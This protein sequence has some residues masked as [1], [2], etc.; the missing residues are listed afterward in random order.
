MVKT[1]RVATEHVAPPVGQAAGLDL[2]MSTQDRNALLVRL[3]LAIRGAEDLADA[4]CHL[5]GTNEEELHRLYQ[6]DQIQRAWFLEELGPEAVQLID[7]A[8]EA[9]WHVP[10][11]GI[12]LARACRRCRRLRLGLEPEVPLP[13]GLPFSLVVAGWFS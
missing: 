12:R 5:P 1:P 11:E 9:R 3:R 6:L 8:E 13:D 2:D 7:D 10:D 4:A